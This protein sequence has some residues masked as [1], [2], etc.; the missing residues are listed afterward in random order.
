MVCRVNVG[1]WELVVEH[2]LAGTRTYEKAGT[3]ARVWKLGKERTS[4]PKSTSSSHVALF[5]VLFL[6]S[7]MRCSFKRRLEDFVHIHKTIEYLHRAD[8]VVI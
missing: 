8:K 6:V 1:R 5:L 7:F 2:R 3:S 4:P